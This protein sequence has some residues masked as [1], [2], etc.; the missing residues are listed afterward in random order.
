[1]YVYFLFCTGF[2]FFQFV[3]HQQQ[4][5]CYLHELLRVVKSECC[6]YRLFTSAKIVVLFMKTSN[7]VVCS[8]IRR[9]SYWS[10]RQG[11]LLRE[12]V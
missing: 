11:F 6:L 5:V 1:M 10:V 8:Q 4:S 9:T 3:Q 7:T 12:T 2:T